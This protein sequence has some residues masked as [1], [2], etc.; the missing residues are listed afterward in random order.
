MDLTRTLTIGVAEIVPTALAGLPE[1]AQAKAPTSIVLLSVGSVYVV[2]EGEASG[3]VAT[4]ANELRATGA[5]VGY[6]VA[7]RS[8]NGTGDTPASGALDITLGWSR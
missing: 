7:I 1:W 5:P 2:G 3:Y 4:A 8:I 6:N